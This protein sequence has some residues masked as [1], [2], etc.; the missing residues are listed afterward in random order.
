MS[1]EKEPGLV[2][3]FERKRDG[4]DESEGPVPVFELVDGRNVVGN[5]LR[6]AFLRDF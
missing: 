6:G 3:L 2:W 5:D 4:A 1:L